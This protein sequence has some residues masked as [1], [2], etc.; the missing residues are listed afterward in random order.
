MSLIV[1]GC[2]ND[3]QNWQVNAAP[4][5]GV[6]CA[7]AFASAGVTEPDRTP[8]VAGVHRFQ[9]STYEEG[10][11]TMKARTIRCTCLGFFALL[12]GGL[13]VDDV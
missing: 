8:R 9:P 5:P 7:L 13:C 6:P 12:G 4:I 10:K 1:A 2:L 3:R 11:R